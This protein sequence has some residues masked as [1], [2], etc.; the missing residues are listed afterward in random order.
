MADENANKAEIGSATHL[1]IEALEKASTE[2]D[3]TV[4][5]SVEQL[6]T[7]NA[8]LEKVFATHLA[9]LAERSAGSVDAN[10]EDLVA[11]KEDFAER[12]GQLERAEMD[13]L[14]AS[15]RAIRGELSARTQ[16]AAESISKLV[17]EQMEQLRLLTDNP[18]AHFKEFGD[19]QIVLIGGFADTHK[20]QL[21]SQQSEQ[22]SHLTIV[23]KSMDDRIQD[24]LG[25]GKRRL[26]ENLEKHQKEY[27][28]KISSL[29]DRLSSIVN[30]TIKELDSQVKMSSMEVSRFNDEARKKLNL[31]VD[32]FEDDISGLGESFQNRLTSDKLSFEQIHAKKLER[33]VA[34]V[35]DEINSISNESALK[36]QASHKLFHSSL[37]RLEKKYYDRLERLIARFETA[38][39][40]ESRLP[41]GTSAYRSQ[42]THEL[43]EVLA[44][45]LKARGTEIVKAFRRQ[46]EQFDS[47][48]ARLASS[49]QERIDGIRSAAL[50]GLD[51][52][53]RNMNLE[54]ER[55][56]RGFKSELVELNSELPQIEDAGRNAALAVMAYRSAMLSFGSE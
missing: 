5:A 22:Q 49:A 47:E 26:D 12:L 43:R 6:N 30:M 45:R 56:M 2:L 19:E 42:T 16:S 53:V 34:E 13:S 11:R 38:I 36:L 31:R 35:K 8:A 24:V 55:V 20:A 54:L 41:A 25:E 48:Y 52:Q 15:A 51:K 4:K 28:E 27:E 21:D 14:V 1:M 46:V 44:A 29:L 33:K 17:E 7:F 10:V 3:K 23:E 40:Q 39:A 50:D 37:K 32:R 18:Q 9:K